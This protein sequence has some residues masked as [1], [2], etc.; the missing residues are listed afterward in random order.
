M[1][2]SSARHILQSSDASFA[3]EESTPA[4]TVADYNTAIAYE[5]DLA[6]ARKAW[7]YGRWLQVTCTM[8]LNN[9]DHDTYLAGEEDTK[10]YA[11]AEINDALI[12]GSESNDA[13]EYVW[14][15]GCG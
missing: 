10:R 6:Y 14:G 1:W 8:D 9:Y 5:N 4:W 2:L 7:D 13:P 15:I 12:L 11:P 3:T